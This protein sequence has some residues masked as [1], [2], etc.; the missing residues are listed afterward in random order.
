MYDLLPACIF[1]HY[2]HAGYPWRS[3][4]GIKSPEL[5]LQS[6]ES[7]HGW[8]ELDSLNVL[9]Q[10]WDYGNCA[11]NGQLLATQTQHI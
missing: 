11:G 9:D 8:S 2:V 3:E 10:S 1:V 6:H 7:P 5:E 4:E